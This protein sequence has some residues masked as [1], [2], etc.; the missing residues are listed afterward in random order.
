MFVTKGGDIMIT[1]TM[2]MFKS[3]SHKEM[4]CC[5][6]TIASS[7]KYEVFPMGP[8]ETCTYVCPK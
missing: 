6:T 4:L 3:N 8:G 1:I 5:N 7:S 2:N